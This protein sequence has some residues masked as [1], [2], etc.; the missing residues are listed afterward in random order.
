MPM[1]PSPTADTSSPWPSF[2]L[3]ILFSSPRPRSGGKVLS[4]WVLSVR[5]VRQAP[6]PGELR[7]QDQRGAHDEAE[8]E[9]HAASGQGRRRLAGEAEEIRSPGPRGRRDGDQDAEAE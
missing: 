8:R 9:K 7:G 5:G 1:A 6:L 2:R 4:W 3:C